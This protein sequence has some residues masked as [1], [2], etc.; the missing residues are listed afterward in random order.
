MHALNGVFVLLAH[1]T[2][3]SCTL[4]KHKSSQVEVIKGSEDAHMDGEIN[5]RMGGK[6]DRKKEIMFMLIHSRLFPHIL[7]VTER[8]QSCRTRG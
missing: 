4:F 6:V 1:G 2:Q 3:L 7:T 5:K 8:F